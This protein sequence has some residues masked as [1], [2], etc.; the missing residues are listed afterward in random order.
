MKV[1]IDTNVILD[2]ALDRE[3]FVKS[4]ALLLKTSQQQ[5]IHLFITATTVTDLYYITRK[6]K[7]KEMALKFLEELLQF[8]DV[9]AVNKWIILEALRAE[10][11]DFEDAIQAYAAKHEAINT[12][13]TRNEGD[14]IGSGLTIYNPESFLQ[15]IT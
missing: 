1:L 11:S 4:A 12:I 7:G 8:I 3:P 15:S 2:I 14:F 5:T 6:E 9:A 13:I 10:I